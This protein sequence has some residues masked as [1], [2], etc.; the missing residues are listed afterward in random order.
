[1]AYDKTKGWYEGTLGKKRFMT[2]PYSNLA[3]CKL[4]G[5]DMTLRVYCQMADNTI[6]EYGV[7]GKSSSQDGLLHHHSQEIDNG[8]WEKMSTLGSAM[9]GTDI[10]CT[11]FKTPEPK[12]R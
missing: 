12:I 6:Q 8:T 10:A 2:A 7:K 5:P 11:V 9:P 3:A 1:M 4:K